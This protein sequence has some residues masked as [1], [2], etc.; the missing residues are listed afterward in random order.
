MDERMVR[1]T[2]RGACWYSRP[3][4]RPAMGD[5]PRACHGPVASSERAGDGTQLVYCDAHANWR[6]RTSRLPLVRR[7]RPG[8]EAESPST[9]TPGTR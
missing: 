8:E 5:C 2:R 1:Q 7:M 9:S 3:E 4:H 6:R